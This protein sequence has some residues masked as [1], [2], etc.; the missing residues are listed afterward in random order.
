MT[1]QDFLRIY[2][3]A[4]EPNSNGEHFD[5]TRDQREM[6]KAKRFMK[7]GLFLEAL[8]IWEKFSA[9][10][11]LLVLVETMTCYYQL[12]KFHDWNRSALELHKI[13]QLNL[14]IQDFPQDIQAKILV[15]TAKFLEEGGWIQ[16]ALNLFEKLKSEMS[17]KEVVEANQ[18]RMKLQY[19]MQDPRIHDSYRSLI[20]YKATQ[21]DL[22]FDVQQALALYESIYINDHLAMLRNQSN[23]QFSSYQQDIALIVMDLLEQFYEKGWDAEN[24]LAQIPELEL[25][26]YESNLLYLIENKN[27]KDPL[28]LFTQ[29][30][31]ANALRLLALYLKK[32]PDIMIQDWSFKMTKS[33]GLEN[34]MIWNR[35]FDL[36]NSGSSVQVS[37]EENQLAIGSEKYDM[38]PVLTKM[39]KTLSSSQGPVCTDHM[40]DMIWG[41][42]NGVSCYER[43]KSAVYRL[44]K[45]L[46]PWTGAKRAILFS[47]ETIALAPF[48]KLDVVSRA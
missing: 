7:R 14:G 10:Q 36:P 20:A 28:F 19:K 6:L 40:M 4:S 22:N 9:T 44:N 16:D 37:L 1:N 24:L 42:T 12:G 34:Q 21:P 30:P 8:Q 5:L 13:Y 43:L 45:I 39:L 26:S 18:L 48:V 35:F 11:N 32:N 38:T 46:K 25:N 33:L 31:T 47:K 3:Q 29:M 23:Y 17:L 15:L 27:L 2:I 41:Q